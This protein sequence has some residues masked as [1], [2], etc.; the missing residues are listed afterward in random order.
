MYKIPCSYPRSFLPQCCRRH[1]SCARSI[2]TSLPIPTHT[3]HHLSPHSTHPK[4]HQLA[5]G[6]AIVSKMARNP[7]S[8]IP[9][10]HKGSRSSASS[11]SGNTRR[12]SGS[13]TTSHRSSTRSASTT[14]AGP[15][16]P[17]VQVNRGPFH[18]STSLG[19]PSEIRRD[20][21]DGG[22][23]TLNEV[24]MAVD[25]MPRGTVG[26]CYYVARDEKLYF[27]EDIQFGEVDVV[28]AR[29]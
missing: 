25:L 16:R 5:A 17:C 23:D 22:N 7:P 4:L 13:T 10:R 29:K 2:G 24:I 8:K 21:E 1:A 28:D 6:T 15:S 18:D 3:S 14:H 20:E 9:Y 19:A 26:C 11:R 27:M 12:T